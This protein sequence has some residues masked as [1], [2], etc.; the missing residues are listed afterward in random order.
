MCIRDR[1]VTNALQSA[2]REGRVNRSYSEIQKD[3]KRQINESAK[4][5]D[6]TGQSIRIP[7]IHPYEIAI[8]TEP[9]LY[10]KALKKRNL[11]NPKANKEANKREKQDYNILKKHREQKILKSIAMKSIIDA[12]QRQVVKEIAKTT[13]SFYANT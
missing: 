4:R 7:S 6:S 10:V 8:P 3:L 11:V 9:E 13:H 1:H 2:S 12:R 5:K